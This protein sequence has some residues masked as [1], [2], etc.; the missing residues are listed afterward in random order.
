M[1]LGIIF[2]KRKAGEQFA[3]VTGLTLVILGEMLIGCL[4]LMALQWRA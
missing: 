4:S 2:G 1:V 3:G